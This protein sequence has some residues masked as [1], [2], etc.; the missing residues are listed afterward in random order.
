[1]AFSPAS[2]TLREPPAILHAASTF[3][4]RK[5]IA[6]DN[7]R[8]LLRRS[9]DGTSLV[10]RV[11]LLSARKSMGYV[12]ISPRTASVVRFESSEI[13]AQQ[14]SKQFVKDVQGTFM[15]MGGEL[16]QFFTGKRTVD[17]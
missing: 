17:Q 4:R 7:T 9:V 16:E 5:A 8:L 6:Y 1:M 2:V 12:Y 14:K 3:A 13:V 10:W 15:N 11:E